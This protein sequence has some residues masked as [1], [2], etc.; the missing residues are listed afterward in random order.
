MADLYT[1]SCGNQVW[2][3]FDTVVRCTACNQEFLTQHTAVAEFN[4]R[5]TQELDEELEEV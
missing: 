2:Q 3:I 1:C 4:H 5:V